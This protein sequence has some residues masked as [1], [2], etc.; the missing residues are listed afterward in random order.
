MSVYSLVGSDRDIFNLTPPTAVTDVIT[1]D[2]YNS[3]I[4]GDQA[5]RETIGELNSFY[6]YRAGASNRSGYRNVFIGALAGEQNARGDNNV[7]IGTEAGRYITTGRGNVLVGNRAGFSNNGNFNVYIGYLNTVQALATSYCNLTIGYDSIINGNNNISFGN[8][9]SIS[10]TDSIVLGNTTINLGKNNIVIGGSIRNQASNVLIINNRHNSNVNNVEFA[11]YSNDYM[12]IND[13]IIANTS[14]NV[15]TLTI[16]NDSVEIRSSNMTLFIATG[17]SFQTQS[18]RFSL[19]SNVILET[20][21]TYATQLLL[22]SNVLLGSSNIRDMYLTASNS[23]VY[24]NSNIIALSNSWGKLAINSNVIIVGDTASN[25]SIILQGSNNVMTLC[26]G[27]AYFDS[28]LQV[29]R[30]AT[31]MSNVFFNS[32]TILR[33]DGNISLSNDYTYRIGGSGE[34]HF[35]QNVCFSNAYPNGVMTFCNVP[36][37]FKNWENVSDNERQ[38]FYGSTVIQKNLFVGGM[39]Y[40]SGINSGNRLVLSSGDNQWN[41]YVS[42]TSN[43]NPYLVFE[44]STG[45]VLRFGD[46]FQPEQLNFTGKHRCFLQSEW[47]GSLIGKIVYATGDYMNLDSKNEISIDES[48]P[49]IELCTTSKDKR[50]FGVISDVE[51]ASQQRC[52][53]LGHLEMLMKKRVDDIRVIV[54]SVGEGGIWVCNASGDFHNGDLITCSD[55]PGFGMK[56]DDDV[57]RSYTVAKIT[58]DCEFNFDLSTQSQKTFCKW[59]PTVLDLSHDGHVYKIAFV[60]CVYKF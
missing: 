50:A 51:Q 45:T 30:N 19:D 12:N 58:C 35:T 15:N 56:Q 20:F 42:V 3:T 23:A 48:I 31:F 52:F 7:L 14:N 44:S 28:K 53:R 6:G 38:E 49:V 41:Q 5:G 59:H 2:D 10:S 1:R 29:V 46:N 27:S 32:N 47:A 17:I 36:Q 22:T 9:S 60:G 34:T 4:V 55:V 25:S 37:G 33:H 40:S 18:G 21:G 26:N 43:M 13:Y 54:N 16:K 24:I 57:I 8:K 11:N 39:I